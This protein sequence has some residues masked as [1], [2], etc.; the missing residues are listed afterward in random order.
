VAASCI[1]FAD[2][3]VAN[4]TDPRI[5]TLPPVANFFGINFAFACSLLPA[6][7]CSSVFFAFC[8]SS[9]PVADFLL[10]PAASFSVADFLLPQQAGL[11][12]DKE[13]L[14]IPSRGKGMPG[15]RDG[16]VLAPDT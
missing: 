11:S 3:C 10:P 15:A 5:L 14:Y 8:C 1:V 4:P 9:R 7:G 6:A 12:K 2:H 16:L 13:T